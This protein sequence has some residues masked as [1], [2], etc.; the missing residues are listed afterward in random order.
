[1]GVC[2]IFDKSVF[3]ELTSMEKNTFIHST[4]NS[5]KQWPV[6]KNMMIIIMSDACT[7]NVLLEHK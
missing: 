7:I 2:Q 4:S 5:N 3:D 1:M 6:L